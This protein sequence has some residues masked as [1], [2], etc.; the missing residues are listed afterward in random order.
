M[1]LIKINEL[2][3]LEFDGSCT[4]S[5]IIQYFKFEFYPILQFLLIIV[6]KILEPL[7]IVTCSPI[8]VQWEILTLVRLALVLIYLL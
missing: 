7:P 6:L 8:Y 1:F 3:Y 4:F 5:A 2:I